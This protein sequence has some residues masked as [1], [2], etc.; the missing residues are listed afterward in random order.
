M[1]AALPQPIE[2]ESHETRAKERQE[3][4]QGHAVTV[5]DKKHHHRQCIH[6]AEDRR[7]GGA[8]IGSNRKK[9]GHQRRSE[10]QTEAQE[11]NPQGWREEAPDAG[12]A[13]VVGY[14]V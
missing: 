9:R 10:E 12:E 6:S 14:F 2:S 5:E 13:V 4:N 3:R 8:R 7:E 1:R 11:W